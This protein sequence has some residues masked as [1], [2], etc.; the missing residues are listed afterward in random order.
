MRLS[1]KFGP[2]VLLCFVGSTALAQ[3]DT[4]KIR[5]NGIDAGEEV[6]VAMSALKAPGQ[7]CFENDEHKKDERT[8]IVRRA[9]DGLV[10]VPNLGRGCVLTV[11]AF[12]RKRAMLLTTLSGWTDQGGEVRTVT[13]K[14]PIDV[15]VV[16]WIADNAVE[17]LAYSHAAHA[18]EYYRNN[19]VG[20]KFV[21]TF[22]NVS[23]DSVK[24][25]RIQRAVIPHPT[26][27]NASVC[28]DIGLLKGHAYKAKTLNVYY[29]S[30][31]NLHRNC[32]IR[33]T[34]DCGD[35]ETDPV[36]F[37]RVDA[38]VTY[39]GV[40]ATTLPVLA[41]ELGHAFGLRPICKFGHPIL[42]PGLDETNIMWNAGGDKR[43]KFTLGQVFRINTQDDRWGGTMIIANK[44]RAGP[45]RKCRLKEQEHS[46]YE[47]PPLNLTLE[48]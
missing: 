46:T 32:A 38:N 7:G 10:T 33:E 27:P 31:E 3:D 36:K 13:M 2:L 14:P 39:I 1:V 29:V 23:G 35:D 47:C 43:V 34:P 17:K 4:D 16:I 26:V 18:A 9:D 11:A 48:P 19:M 6:L 20:F 45:G 42:G 21:P 5:I 40:D 28:S 8:W 37:A 12:S 30:R 24:V 41:H 44:L 22:K 15:P 25:D